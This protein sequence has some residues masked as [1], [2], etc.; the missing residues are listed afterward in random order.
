M[1]QDIFFKTNADIL[2]KIRDLQDQ[3]HKL[4]NQLNTIDNNLN[5]LRIHLQPTCPHSLSNYHDVFDTYNKKCDICNKLIYIPK[6][7]R[8]IF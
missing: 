3:R 6:S 1:N 8:Q 2:N 4:L 7:Q 5:Q